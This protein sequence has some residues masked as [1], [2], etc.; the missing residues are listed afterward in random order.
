VIITP[1]M[2]TPAPVPTPM[3]IKNPGQLP[4]RRAMGA[5]P[6]RAMGFFFFGS[7]PEMETTGIYFQ[8]LILAWEFF[9]TKRCYQLAELGVG[10]MVTLYVPVP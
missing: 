5:I 2:A 8:D 6:N 9:F 4:M 1:D 7:Y 10:L 3:R